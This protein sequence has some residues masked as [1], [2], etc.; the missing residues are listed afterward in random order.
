MKYG[1]IYHKQTG[2]IGDD[3]QAYAASRLLP[4]VDYML[5]REHLDTFQSKEDE[6]VAAIMSAW[7]T[8]AKWNWPPSA[9]IYPKFVGFH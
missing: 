2:N 8:W 5:D 4:R 9:S 3:I 6:P 1:V 7:Y